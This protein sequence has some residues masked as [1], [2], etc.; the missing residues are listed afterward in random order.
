M[1]TDF[2]AEEEKT[3]VLRQEV[4]CKKEPYSPK[5]IAFTV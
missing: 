4:I 1:N 3:N 2:Q 5:T